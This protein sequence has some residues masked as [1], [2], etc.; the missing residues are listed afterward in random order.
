[1]AAA[2]DLVKTDRAYYAATPAPRLQRF[3]PIHY[4]TLDG[5]GEPGSGEFALATQALYASAYGVKKLYKQEQRD[6]A[7]PKLEGLWWVD[8][9][10]LALEVPRGEWQWKLM[11]RMPDFV[12]KR[13]VETAKASVAAAKKNELVRRVT[14]ETLEEGPCVQAMH[15]GPY[16]QE[17]VTIAS[18]L[19]FVTEKGLKVSGLHHEIYISDPRKSVPEKMQTIIRYPVS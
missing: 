14:F 13:N 12:V 17:P 7:V 10:R 9:T 5:K 2:T 11:L 3:G 16:A 6:F 19:R 8:G 4:L 18:L 1:M 15:I